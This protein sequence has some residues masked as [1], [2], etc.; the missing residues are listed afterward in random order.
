M[1]AEHENVL[2]LALIKATEYGFRLFKNA[3]G[4]GYVG[5]LTKS[6][7][8]SFAGEIVTI[9]KA[10]RVKFGVCNPGGFDLIGWQT[11]K[12]TADMAGMR[13]AVFTA[14]DG[15]TEGYATMSKDQRNF[16]RELIKAGGSAIIARRTKDRESVDF[17]QLT[18]GDFGK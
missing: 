15:K 11:V 6:Y 2:T 18:S 7:R 3:M 9:E 14:I 13:L 10:R 17:V 4:L 5:K 12:I 1:A 16:A 8:D